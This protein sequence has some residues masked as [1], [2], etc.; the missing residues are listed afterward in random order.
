M[1]TQR[2]KTSAGDEYLELVRQFP[3]KPIRHESD[4]AEAI[5]L[6]A[7]LA[8]RFEQLS[9]DQKEYVEALSI[10]V[11]DFERR[12]HDDRLSLRRTTPLERLRF[13]M[14]ENDISVSDLGRI[15]GS[16]SAASMVLTGQLS[17]SKSHIARP[18]RRSNVNSGLFIDLDQP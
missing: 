11:R 17:L 5:R 16:Q 8:G 2:P 10:L 1:K 9:P 6:L 3:L 18:A 14:P 12:H 15:I 7:P 4:H 13:L